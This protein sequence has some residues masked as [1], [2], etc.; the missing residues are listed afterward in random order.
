MEQK[1]IENLL[2]YFIGVVAAFVVFVAIKQTSDTVLFPSI[3]AIVGS[4]VALVRF[5]RKTK[6]NPFKELFNLLKDDYVLDK[7]AFLSLT[8]IVY[9]ITQ[10]A[11]V[12]SALGF[13]IDWIHAL[14]NQ[15]PASIYLVSILTCFIVLLVVRVLLELY[16][17]LFRAALDLRKYVNK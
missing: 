1:K 5:S 10:G 11:C 9:A 3:L 2:I 14:V 12:G 8:S 13:T 15:Y 7:Y 16:S 17:V 4:I 6:R